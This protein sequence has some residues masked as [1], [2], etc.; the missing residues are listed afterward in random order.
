MSVGYI[1]G[2]PLTDIY[3]DFNGRISFANRMGLLSDKL[4]QVMSVFII[5]WDGDL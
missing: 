5:V 2:N 4:Y 3:A 1:L